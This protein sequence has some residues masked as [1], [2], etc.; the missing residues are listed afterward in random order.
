MSAIL[1]MGLIPREREGPAR[2]GLESVLITV[3]FLGV[4]WL[5]IR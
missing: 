3:L 5:L 4:V 1:I 2:I